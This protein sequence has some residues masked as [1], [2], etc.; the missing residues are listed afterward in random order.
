MSSS[1]SPDLFLGR[2]A[3]DAAGASNERV[4]LHAPQEHRARITRNRFVTIA[5]Q[6]TAGLVFLGRVLGGP[7]FPQ[8]NGEGV[9]VAELEVQGELV[10]GEPGRTTT[11][12]R[13]ARPSTSCLPKTSAACWG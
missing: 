6:R 3:E 1:P 12:R 11:G 4:V 8:P 5:D 7:F 10:G 2:V 9:I 13:Q